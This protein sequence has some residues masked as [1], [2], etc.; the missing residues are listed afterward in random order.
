[1]PDGDLEG[2]GQVEQAGSGEPAEDIP[3]PLDPSPRTAEF[4]PGMSGQQVHDT[5]A[6]LSSDRGAVGVATL[7]V[8]YGLKALGKEGVRLSSASGHSGTGAVITG[9]VEG[10]RLPPGGC[11]VMAGVVSFSAG[12]RRGPRE[13]GRLRRGRY[14]WWGTANVSVREPTG[15]PNSRPN[16]HRVSV[17]I[18]CI[19]GDRRGETGIGAQESEA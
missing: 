5:V 15:C 9:A 7:P 17:R 2:K 11:C 3:A 6:G 19:D 16:R 10:L 1:M 18:G 12:S 4:S 8:D 13:T 14:S